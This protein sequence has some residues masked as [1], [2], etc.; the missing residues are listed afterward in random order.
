MNDH[1][2]KTAGETLNRLLEALICTT[3]SILETVGQTLIVAA[4]A[5][6]RKIACHLQRTFCPN[7]NTVL[8]LPRTCFLL[9]QTLYF[10][11]LLIFAEMLCGL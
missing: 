7:F 6:V 1:H 3:L 5:G 9:F 2:I 10:T 11:Q 4:N 8:S